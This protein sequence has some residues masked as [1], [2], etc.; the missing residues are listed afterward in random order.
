MKR[1]FLR[2]FVAFAILFA[3]TSCQKEEDMGR[4]ITATMERYES[5]TKAYINDQNYACWEN[6]DLV[7]IN[8]T[9]C[10]LTVASGSQSATLSVPS[11]M[12]DQD[13][14]AC[15]PASIVGN[16][17]ATGGTVT[18]PPFQVY[19]VN[20]D[21]RQ[22]IDN[23]MAAYCPADGSELKFRNLCALLKVTLPQTDG[24]V[25]KYISVKGR[26]G[27]NLYGTA[28]LTLDSERKPYLTDFI[29]GG[30]R[31]V[32][33]GIDASLTSGDRS[34]YIVVPAFSVF[35]N[36]TITVILQKADRKA[37]RIT[38]TN[39][40]FNH[41]VDRNHIGAFTYNLDGDEQV[42]K[43]LL[44]AT[45]DHSEV[46]PQGMSVVAQEYGYI[47][48]DETVTTIG[49]SAF[50]GRSSLAFVTLPEGVT[51]IGK[52]AFRGCSKLAS[53]T[54]PENVTTIGEYAFS[55][56][57]KLASIN[58]PEGVTTIGESAFS[59]CASLASVTLP[60]TVTT[61]GESAFSGCSSLA[62]VTLPEGVTTIGKSA[63]R[64]CSSLA[65]VTLPEGLTTIGEFTFSGCS[66]LA[67][68]TLPSMLTTIGNYAFYYCSNLASISLPEGLTSI[69]ERA[70][71]LC[72]SLTEV[73][74]LRP[75]NTA[76]EITQGGSEMFNL[77]PGSLHIYVPSNSVETY[78]N[79]PCWGDYQGKISAR[80]SSK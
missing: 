32:L 31:I 33:T 71:E 18:L 25:V 72:E 58:V 11:G 46:T 48:F 1:L 56:C 3:A 51:T 40:G 55:G 66:S 76:E 65:F 64:G 69:G 34:F 74:V 80:P 60:E 68:I 30:E 35:S 59:G 13:L 41:V 54:L 23:P 16:H 77:C 67:S 49:V 57:S 79:A 29:D 12:E 75:G 42:G 6:D 50:S 47:M 27:Q 36:M 78:Q 61:I 53:V 26:S 73:D 52:S 17:S 15:Y 2:S 37:Y 44:Y 38:K 21:G 62:S 8:G 19:K 24:A 43:L 10:T 63:F 45:T 9:Q 14:L 20:G 28:Q 22:I 70:F 39:E 4:V 7:S 5:A